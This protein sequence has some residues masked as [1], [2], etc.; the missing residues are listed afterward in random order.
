MISLTMLLAKYFVFGIAAH[1]LE[2]QRRALSGSEPYSVKPHRAGNILEVLLSNVLEGEVE[3][4]GY[5]LLV[6]LIFHAVL[7][8]GRTAQCIDHT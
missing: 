5:V 2:R 6:S 3:S 4:S 8:F 1:V 7:P